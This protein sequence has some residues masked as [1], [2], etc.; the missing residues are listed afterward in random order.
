MHA[1]FLGAAFALPGPTGGSSQDCQDF[2][3]GGRETEDGASGGLPVQLWGLRR[4]D[5]AGRVSSQVTW[6][7]GIQS[8]N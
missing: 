4:S 5:F 8:R 6:L 2:Y 1:L 3:L 7:V